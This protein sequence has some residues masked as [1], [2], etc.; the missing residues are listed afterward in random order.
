MAGKLLKFVI[1]SNVGTQGANPGATVQCAHPGWGA[2]VAH[3]F[4]K[5]LAC[6]PL[7]GYISVYIYVHTH[8]HTHISRERGGGEG[9]N[10]KV[11]NGSAPPRV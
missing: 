11:G 9:L 3:L 4:I 1:L 10:E 8:T 2:P 5:S 6:P 7:P